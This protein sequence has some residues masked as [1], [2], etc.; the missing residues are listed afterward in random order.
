MNVC[1]GKT[2]RFKRIY[3]PQQMPD[4]EGTNFYVSSN[5]KV[6]FAYCFVLLADIWDCIDNHFHENWGH[7][8]DKIC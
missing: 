1:K 4:A 8:L 2:P 3:L 5:D 6:V 7:F